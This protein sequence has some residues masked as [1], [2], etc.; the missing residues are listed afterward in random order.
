MMEDKIKNILN[1]LDVEQTEK[2][3]IDG[4]KFKIDKRL[5]DNIKKTVYMKTGIK[6]KR[7]ISFKRVFV[8]IMVAL[9][10]IITSLNVIGI[11]KVVAYI[12]NVFKFLPGYGIVENDDMY[13][14]EQAGSIEN[15]D[16]VFQLNNAIG[17]KDSISIMFTTKMKNYSDP[18]VKENTNG[19]ENPNLILY[20]NNKECK[21]Y[22]YSMGD[23]GYGVVSGTFTYSL[24]PEDINVN[25]LYKLYYE[26]YNLSLE[27]K[28]KDVQTFG[29]LE[30]IGPT[31]YN[32]DISVTAVPSFYGDKLE[33]NLYSIANSKFHIE[34]YCKFS[35]K[36]Y[37]GEDMTLET[38]SGVKNYVMPDATWD[39]YNKFEFNVE[40]T[41]KN[42]I[43]RIPYLIVNAYNEE[44]IANIKIPEDG[45]KITINERIDFQDSSMI[46]TDV[47]KVK[48]DDGT[49]FGY[50]Y[51][52]MNI[53]YENKHE[54]IIMKGAAFNRV[55]IFGKFIGGGYYIE[56]DDNNEI[57]TLGYY[58]QKDDRGTLRLK[59]SNPS[60]YITDEY[61]LKF[62]R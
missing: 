61:V 60:F 56:T 20:V 3:L 25:N 23:S 47:E 39:G 27:F 21:M 1:D 24:K 29:K 33:V 54:N 19:P 44:K 46:I 49:G 55:N 57:T 10:I 48:D 35:N 28:L 18:D 6:E 42:F 22:S 52:K 40:P 36:G 4:M 41:D 5:K 37:K 8:T 34:S 11:D 31:G 43:L 38:E 9:L 53:R 7:K 12:S 26:K 17:T 59:V 14:I 13:V 62:N 32:N 45:E 51:L 50:G 30:D 58:L 2:L 15:D 16:V